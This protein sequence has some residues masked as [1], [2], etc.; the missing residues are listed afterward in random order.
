MR[1]KPADAEADIAAVVPARLRFTELSLV[2]EASEI[3][4]PV[5]TAM[6]IVE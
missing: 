6:K 5:V 4:T 3:A 2:R 1:L